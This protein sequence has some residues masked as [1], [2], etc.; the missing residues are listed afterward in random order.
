MSHETTSRVAAVLG[1]LGLL[2]LLALGGCGGDGAQPVRP[3]TA[4]LSPKLATTRVSR[5][6][7]AAH[8]KLQIERLHA[9]ALAGKFP[10][11]P[12][13]SPVPLHMFRDAGGAL[14]PIANLIHR[15][16]HEALVD[17][18]AKE[19][20][21]VVVA[22][23][24]EGPLHEWVLTS[25]LTNEEVRRIQGVGFP[26]EGGLL[27]GGLP[28]SVVAHLDLRAHLEAVEK[29]LEN[30]T[31]ASLDVALARLAR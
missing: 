12:S 31:E 19:H 28:P 26:G 14:C 16:G 11:N 7:L 22:D 13:P 21:D 8:R 6:Q 5:D 27:P 15:D 2:G 9:Y 30:D 24:T 20:N 10:Q 25:G 1:L 18:M 23:E 17:R 29:E 4:E 3:A